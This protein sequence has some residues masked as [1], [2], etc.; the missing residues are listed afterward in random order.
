LQPIS[1][2]TDR[3][4]GEH[5]QLTGRIKVPVVL[6]NNRVD[7]TVPPR[8]ARVYPE[9]VAAAGSSDHLVVLPQVGEGHCDFSPE[10]IS[11]AFGKLVDSAE[12]GE[13]PSAN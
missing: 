9:L 8:F 2:K 3:L 6:L 12:R 5:A 1:F 11:A 4:L 13:K 7:Q 10:Q